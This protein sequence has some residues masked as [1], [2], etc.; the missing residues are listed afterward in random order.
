[1]D[2]KDLEKELGDINAKK[3]GPGKRIDLTV[4]HAG[5]KVIT[6][7]IIA[8]LFFIAIVS[9]GMYTALNADIAGIDFKVAA[10]LAIVYMAL[11][12]YVALKLW[13][14]EFMGWLALFFISL[15][16]IALPAM[17]A[18]NH[19][20]MIG[21][22]PIIVVSIA[23]LIVLFWIKDLYRVKKFGDIFGPPQ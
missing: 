2:L 5:L 18:M 20:L 1:M 10:A 15:V 7:K 16:G 3:A 22:L 6:S 19:G 8:V 9:F 13:N 17:S 11:G 4:K 14:I 12:A 23:T 21:T